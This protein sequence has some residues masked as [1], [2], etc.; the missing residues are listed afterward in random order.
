MSTGF[1]SII[2]ILN[3]KIITIITNISASTTTLCLKKN[4]TPIT[5]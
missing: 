5:F 1:A 2:V 4:R 3:V